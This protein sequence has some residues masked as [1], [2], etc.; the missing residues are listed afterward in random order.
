MGLGDKIR[1]AITGSIGADPVTA[2]LTPK[3]KAAQTGDF[4]RSSTAGHVT[5]GLDQAMRDHADR[6]HPVAKPKMGA[7]WDQ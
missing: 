5:S 6:E 1:G 4:V 2:A 3:V 7:D